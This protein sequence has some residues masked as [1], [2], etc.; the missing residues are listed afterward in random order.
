MVP[1]RP[2]GPPGPSVATRPPIGHVVLPGCEGVLALYDVGAMVLADVGTGL[3]HRAVMEV[4]SPMLAPSS[5]HVG[6]GG[7]PGGFESIT[8]CF[9]VALQSH[10]Q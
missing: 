3:Y 2:A 6:D 7:A 10:K 9:A 4:N 1:K 5:T 8:A